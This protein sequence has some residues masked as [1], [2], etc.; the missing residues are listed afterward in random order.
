MFWNYRDDLS[1]NQYLFVD[2]ANSL[3]F[4][5]VISKTAAS[6]KLHKESFG[7]FDSPKIIVSIVAQL[8]ICNALLVIKTN[9]TTISNITI[10]TI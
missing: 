2:A 8:L 7:R 3:F 9:I 5:L 10:I 1:N 4:C 6:N